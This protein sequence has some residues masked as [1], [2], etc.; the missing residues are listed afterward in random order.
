MEH[1]RER[2][3]SLI[4]AIEVCRPGSDDLSDP[5]LSALREELAR[6][7]EMKAMY[8]RVQ[9]LD[10]KIGQAFRAVSVPDGLAERI[11][12]RLG[13]DDME[14]DTQVPCDLQPQESIVATAGRMRWKWLIGAG[15]TLATAAAVVIAVLVFSN[16]ND[17]PVAGADVRQA[18]MAQFALDLGTFGTGLSPIQE[19][20]PAGYPVSSEVIL[21]GVRWRWVDDLLLER[22][23]VAYDV[24]LPAGGRATL[25]V[26][27]AKS[28]G[29]PTAP[30][31]RARGTGNRSVAAWKSG[32]LV[33]VLVLDQPG[34]Y[35]KLL[36]PRGPIT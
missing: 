2:E 20:P 35:P 36:A 1:E 6:N 15:A 26:L 4:E 21:R 10:T 5:H 9:E 28:A 34:M 23:A 18:A 32:D 13:Q 27:K 31:A 7:P 16:A 12:D 3:R 25:Y 22:K 19:A 14:S 29:L 17:Q 24:S 8:D 11:L 30:P 33:Y